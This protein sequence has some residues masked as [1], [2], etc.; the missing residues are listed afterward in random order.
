MSQEQLNKRYIKITDK[1]NDKV[2]KFHTDIPIG[3]MWNLGSKPQIKDKTNITKEERVLL[4]TYNKAMLCAFSMNPKLVLEMP[5]EK[6]R[7]PDFEYVEVESLDSLFFT[8]T[9][10]AVF[11]QYQKQQS[12][13]LPKNASQTPSQPK[14]AFLTNPPITTTDSPSQTKS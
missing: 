7:N 2:Y 13:F 9:I 5:P 11:R 8:Q 4:Q 6:D 12:A 10:T 1:R 3:V 14:P